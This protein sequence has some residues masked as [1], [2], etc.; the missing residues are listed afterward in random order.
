MQMRQAMWSGACI[1]LSA[2]AGDGAGLDESGRPLEDAAQT[3]EPTL[4]SI[5][6]NVFTPVCTTCH[7]GAA[8]PLG[9]RLEEGVAFAMLV[10]APSVEQPALLRV[11]PG[12][13]DVSYLIQKLEGT[14]AVGARM[15][16]NG[17]PLP[18]DTIAVI[19][20]WIANGAPAQASA[21]IPVIK[22][23]WP[24]N[25]AVL[26]GPPRELV[27]S[28]TAELDATLLDAGVIA[29]RA[30]GGDGDFTNGNEIGVGARVTLRSLDPSVFALT[31]PEPWRAD[32]YELRISGGAPL[33]LADRNAQLIDG[34]EDGA[35]GGDFVL[36]FSVESSP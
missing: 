1:A 32:H 33:A 10:N 5:Q 34:D 31:L 3:L 19:R 16:L 30:S 26:S 24:T 6:R 29:L 4:A 25:D 28:A 2:C 8:A 27:L 20:Q 36:R 18:P 11:T 22:A 9:L 14:A 13:A 15:P 12:N 35:P 23:V 17:P 7:A 21:R